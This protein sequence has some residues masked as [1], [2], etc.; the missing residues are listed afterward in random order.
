MGYQERSSVFVHRILV[1]VICLGQRTHP[2]L[3][4][5]STKGTPLGTCI[6]MAFKMVELQKTHFSSNR[7]LTSSNKKLVETSA[8][9]V[10]TGATLVETSA[11]LVVTSAL[12]V[13]TGL[14]LYLRLHI[15]FLLPDGL[16]NEHRTAIEKKTK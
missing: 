3:E 6:K 11:T 16:T 7:C 4:A 1:C 2:L 13:V 15:S 9:L 12:L 10:V 5:S 14:P 8:T